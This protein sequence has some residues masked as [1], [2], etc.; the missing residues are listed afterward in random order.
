MKICYGIILFS[1]IKEEIDFIEK[2]IFLAKKIEWA[3]LHIHIS[4]HNKALLETFCSNL[5]HENLTFDLDLAN[6]GYGGGFNKTLRYA[7]FTNSDLVVFSNTDINFNDACFIKWINEI[8]SNNYYVAPIQKLHSGRLVYGSRFRVFPI[9]SAIT[10]AN[11][12]INSALGA[13]M[14]AKKEQFSV[15]M[16]ES[17]FMYNEEHAYFNELSKIMDIVPTENFYFTHQGVQSSSSIFRLVMIR[18]NLGK[19]CSAVHKNWAL[20]ALSF[21]LNYISLSIRINWLKVNK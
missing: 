17:Y 9:S 18:K 1:G 3:D 19:L 16:D 10:V 15:L 8:M 13:I 4:V 5:V 14:Y 12:K 20:R 21:I 2:L 6:S 11:H 7:L